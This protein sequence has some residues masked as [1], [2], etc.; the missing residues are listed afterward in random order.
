MSAKY[1]KDTT[2]LARQ[3]LDAFIEFACLDWLLFALNRV[4]C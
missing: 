2:L 4:N 1:L 3:L